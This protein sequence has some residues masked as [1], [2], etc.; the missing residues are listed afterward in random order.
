[1]RVFLAVEVNSKEVVERLLQAQRRIVLCGTNVRLVESENLHFTVRFFGEMSEKEV[2]GT[3]NRLKDMKIAPIRVTYAGLGTFPGYS[4]ISVIWV[5]VDHKGSE[6][7][8]HI[9]KEIEERLRG[10]VAGDQKS[11]HPHITIARVRSS[12]P[13]EKL[14]DLIRS[15]YDTVFGDDVLTSLK[16]KQSELTSTGP[17]YTDLY[18]LPF[19]DV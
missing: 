5:G 6:L 9:A 18:N 16:M 8:A 17:I 2:E 7:L 10:L 11:F 12:R 14:V 13:G 1:M 3:W 19:R 4:R 15:S